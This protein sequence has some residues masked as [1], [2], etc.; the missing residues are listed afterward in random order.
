MEQFTFTLLL[1]YLYHRFSITFII[2]MLGVVIRILM[3]NVNLHQKVSIGK[4]I[5]STM[6]ST[7]LMCAVSELVPFSFTVYVL[8]CVI[9]GM[10]SMKIVSLGL[11]S[12]F[13]SKVL[14]RYIKSIAE[15]I[16]DAL[17]EENN[18]VDRSKDKKDNK[19]GEG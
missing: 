19:S 18:D 4:V 15:P 13:M 11:N 2:T 5:A 10:W 9:A 1:D 14:S 16:A 6:F 17:E 12:K 3:S 8:V 7:V